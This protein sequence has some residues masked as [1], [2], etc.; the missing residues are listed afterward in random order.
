M[1]GTLLLFLKLSND[2]K[3]I[4]E[5]YVNNANFMESINYFLNLN[6]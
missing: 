6:P 1:E 5:D 2:T 3:E 4:V